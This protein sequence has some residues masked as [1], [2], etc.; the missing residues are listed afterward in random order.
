MEDA[1]ESNVLNDNIS[2]CHCVAIHFRERRG[3]CRILPYDFEWNKNGRAPRGL[4]PYR[5]WYKRPSRG[6][7]LKYT[8]QSL[9]SVT[10]IMRACTVCKYIAVINIMRT[11]LD[12][13]PKGWVWYWILFNTRWDNWYW[14]AARLW[15][16]GNE[17]N[18]VQAFREQTVCQLSVDGAKISQPL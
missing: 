8:T 13:L 9:C 2:A 12:Y 14:K 17:E 4:N 5:I 1:A 3:K 7:I 15:I 10:R 11:T 16:I 18:G 6:L